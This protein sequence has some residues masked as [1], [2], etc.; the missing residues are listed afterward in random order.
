MRRKS[1]VPLLIGAVAAILI[2]VA[3]FMFIGKSR[4]SHTPE[5]VIAAF[6]QYEQT[7]D[8]GNAWELFHPEMQTKFPKSTYIQTK[9]HV[10][11]GHMG[12]DEFKVK[13]G[14]VEKVDTFTFNQEG[15]TFK[16]VRKADVDL[17]FDSQFGKLT[18]RQTC[19]VALEEDE[20]KVL[21]DYHF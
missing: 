16:K 19:Y 9:N 8:F 5:E 4:E 18:I 2:V 10:F 20:W 3:L 15:L 1:P 21:W 12:V 7:G 17:F 13:V 14:K 6:Y 11:M